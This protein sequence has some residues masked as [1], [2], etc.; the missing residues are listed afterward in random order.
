MPDHGERT[1]NQR[2]PTT[3]SELTTSDA[4]PRDYYVASVHML[5]ADPDVLVH[6]RKEKKIE[7]THL[8]GLVW[9]PRIHVSYNSINRA[10]SS[11]PANYGKYRI[12]GDQGKTRPDLGT[13]TWGADEAWY[14]CKAITVSPPNESSRQ[15]L[16]QPRKTKKPNI[17][18]TYLELKSNQPE[19]KNSQPA[20]MEALTKAELKS[21]LSGLTSGQRRAGSVSTGRHARPNM[22]LS[23]RP[24]GCRDLHSQFYCH[25]LAVN[26][27]Q[28]L[29]L[30]RIKL[31][32]HALVGASAGGRVK[33]ACPAL[34]IICRGFEA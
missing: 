26:R 20:P 17:L 33:V 7:G 14:G 28:A 1:N 16:S 29:G 9:L 5:I 4:Q 12:S 8:E 23:G 32:L 31:S 25:A 13:G 18:D 34:L 10:C 2:R 22:E 19:R 24:H 21:S 27:N 11:G 15:R 30:N 6:R 3:G